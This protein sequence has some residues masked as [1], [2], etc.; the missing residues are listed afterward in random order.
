MN[1]LFLTLFLLAATLGVPDAFTDDARQVDVTVISDERAQQLFQEFK[2][3]TEIPFGFS[4]DGCYA[5]A[6][7]MAKIA[8]EEK[9]E[10]GKVWAKGFLRV[11]TNNPV[12]PDVEWGYHVAPILYVKAP[13]GTV[14]LMVFDPSLFAKPVPVDEWTNKM[15]ADGD[16][17]ANVDKVY[18]G[19]RF[20]YGQ[21]GWE[22][23]KYNWH[24]EDI[25]ASKVVMTYYSEVLEQINQMRDPHTRS[26]SVYRGV[27]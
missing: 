10:M 27:K 12:F 11:K 4:V 5:R 17:K 9:I 6:T 16:P 18:Y 15:T 19:A 3:H 13:N 21:L 22:E 24:T 23:K 25:R 8:E 20:Q 14:K 7:A 2:N 1:F 26:D